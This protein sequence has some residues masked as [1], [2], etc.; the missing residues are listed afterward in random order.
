[1]YGYCEKGDLGSLMAKS[2][3]S[4]AGSMGAPAAACIHRGHSRA[5]GGTLHSLP[6]NRPAPA[7]TRL[8][9]QGKPFPEPTLK[10]WLCEMLL[11][12]EYLQV[13]KVLHR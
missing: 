3:V 9:A 1:V 11:A 12:L 10:L 2:G 6:Y 7:R 4:G 5:R 13:H 8:R